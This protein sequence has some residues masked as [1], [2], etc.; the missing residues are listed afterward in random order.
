MSFLSG[1]FAH[2]FAACLF[3]AVLA[4]PA[5]VFAQD[6]VVSPAELQKDTAASATVRQHNIESLQKTFSEPKVENALRAANIDPA[7]V[8]TAVSSLSDAELARLTA[9][10]NQ[11]QQDFSAGTLTDR[12]LLL[13]LVFFAALILIIVAVH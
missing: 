9:K 11:A 13:L 1:R 4:V 12:D 7:Q 2:V 5:H 10:A 8:K 3:L 6:H